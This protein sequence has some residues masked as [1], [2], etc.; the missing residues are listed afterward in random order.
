MT[1][2]SRA[3]RRLQGH[4]DRVRRPSSVRPQAPRPRHKPTLFW[5][6]NQIEHAPATWGD[7]PYL[8]APFL[9]SR[10][11]F[12]SSIPRPC[13]CCS[14]PPPTSLASSR[15]LPSRRRGA[16]AARWAR[17]CRTVSARPPPP[18]TPALRAASPSVLRRGCHRCRL[19]AHTR[20]Q[21]A[22]ARPLPLLPDARTLP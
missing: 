2:S 10:C 14:S 12:N 19:A 15:R 21:G 5:G 20:W 22:P 1:S 7:R 13:T 18:S 9:L 3:S 17:R 16:E 11:R 6:P 8:T 4:R